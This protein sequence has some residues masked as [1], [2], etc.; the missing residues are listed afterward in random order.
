MG[1]GATEIT[2]EFVSICTQ[3]IWESNIDIPE[4]L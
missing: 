4:F 1:E 2:A 3:F